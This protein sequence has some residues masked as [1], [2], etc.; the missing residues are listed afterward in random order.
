MKL[1]FHPLYLTMAGLLFILNIFDLNNNI[2]TAYV[3]LLSGKA[4]CYDQE[5]NERKTLVE[6][7]RT[8]TCYVPSLKNVPSTIFFTDIKSIKDTT[9]LWVNELYAKYMAKHYIISAPTSVVIKSN[10]E[11]IKE[12]AKELR[13]KMTE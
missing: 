13:A 7:C 1:F 6:Q 4:K 10:F 5:L 2:T 12:T 8:D 11:T 3:D 9:N